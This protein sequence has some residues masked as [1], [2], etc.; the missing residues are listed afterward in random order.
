MLGSLTDD[1]H[2]KFSMKISIKSFSTIT[3][4]NR[5]KNKRKKKKK[6]NE[7]L[8]YMKEAAHQNIQVKIPT[9]GQISRDTTTYFKPVQALD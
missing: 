8:L 2:R 5:H 7:K 4:K 1:T 6:K 9:Q 3:I